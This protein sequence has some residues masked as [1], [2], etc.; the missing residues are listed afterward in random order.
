MKSFVRNIEKVTKKDLEKK[1]KS[2][3]VTKKKKKVKAK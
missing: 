2:I 3:I 1:A